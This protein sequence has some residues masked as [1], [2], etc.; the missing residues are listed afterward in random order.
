MRDVI[1]TIIGIWVF[2]KLYTA[3]VSRNSTV[4]QKNEHH[5]YHTEP[6]VKINQ[7]TDTKTKRNIDDAEY[8]DFEEI[9]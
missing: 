6:E 8:T 4:Y 9:K 1:W 7:T 5:H 2:Y 3:F